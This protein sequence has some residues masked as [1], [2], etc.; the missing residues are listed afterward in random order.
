MRKIQISSLLFLAVLLSISVTAQKKSSKNVV[1]ASSSILL[2]KNENARLAIDLQGGAIVDFHLKASKIN[3]FTW[4]VTT[5]QMPENNKCGAVFQGHFIC[6]GRWGAPTEGEMKAGVP[7]N[8]QAGRDLWKLES[9][10]KAGFAKMTA[11][12]PLDGISVERNIQ[13]DDKSAV[14]KVSEKVK[15]VTTIG[16]LFNIVQHATI[17]APFL[18]STTLIDSNA[19]QG[20]LQTMCYP[21]PAAHEFIFPNAYADSTRAPLNLRTS[22]NKDSYVSTHI[23]ADSIGWIVAATPSN[24]L[25]VGYV[26]KT[27]D[28]PWLNLWQQCV[29]G[30]LWAK[31]LEFGTSGVGKSYQELL[32][33]DTRFYGQSSFF[34]LD[35]TE[36]VAKSYIGFEIEIPANFT[37][38]EN[39]KFSNNCIE[40][41]AK[42][43]NGERNTFKISTNLNL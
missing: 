36:T 33:V 39:L 19:K 35:A 8:G 40:L 28:Y 15:N 2:L 18:D 3:P 31:G 9:A 38:V 23:F 37:G 30:K 29:D 4:K 6:L 13:M 27:A 32:A 43:S 10:Q 14:Y 16:R 34:F 20:F 21:N 24:G 22:N 11:N 25:L 7:H 5:A 26:W 1:K 42:T 41:D 17:G 12:A